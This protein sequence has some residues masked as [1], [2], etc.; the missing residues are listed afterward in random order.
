MARFWT[1]H[2]W[3]RSLHRWGG[4]VQEREA[5]FVCRLLRLFAFF[6]VFGV[7]LVFGPRVGRSSQDFTKIQ[8][9]DGTNIRY[10]VVL[11]EPTE[12]GRKYP[13]ILAFPGG[14]QNMIQVRW[15]LHNIWRSEAEK[16]GYVVISPAAVRGRLYFKRGAEY[17]PEFLDLMIERYPIDPE[18]VHVAGMSNGGT[19][20]FRIA[21][22]MPERFRSI[23][24][25][26]GYL[27]GTDASGYRDLLPLCVVMFAGAKD[28]GWVKALERDR[29]IF[30]ALG[31]T[32]FSEVIPGAGHVPRQLTRS[33]SARL[34]DL[35]ESRAG[36]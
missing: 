3:G 8:I 22:L 14:A 6:V 9:A 7:V 25:L 18:A 16:R 32:V 20:A 29:E 27:G 5:M 10:A 26:P 33:G 31:K 4:A 1:S 36:C 15:G 11:P 24:T 21:S 34:F 2:D 30:K 19:S 23:L 35:I 17:F 12:P 28:R 13:A